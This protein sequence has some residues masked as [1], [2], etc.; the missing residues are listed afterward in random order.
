MSTLSV[1]LPNSLHN[2]ARELA[3][4]EDVSI[5][6][7]IAVALA[8][9]VSALTTESYLE[10]RARRGSLKHFQQVMDRVPHIEPEPQDRL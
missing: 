7:F 6:Q 4:Q 1:R 9:K 2:A 10:E 5:N 8:E 3:K